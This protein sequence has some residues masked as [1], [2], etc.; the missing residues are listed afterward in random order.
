MGHFEMR[1]L[2]RPLNALVRV[3][4]SKSLTNRALVAAALARGTSTLTNLLVADDTERMLDVLQALGI[5]LCV[6]SERHKATV[7]GCG[8]HIPAGEAELFTGGA[9]TVMRFATAMCA[10]GHG[11]YRLDGDAQ[12]RQRPIADLVAALRSLGALVDY[13]GREGFPPVVVHARGLAGG[14]VSFESPPSSQMVSAVLLAA[15]CARSDVFVEVAGAL[16]SEPYLAMTLEVMDAFG[17]TVVHEALRRFIVP[18]PQIYQSRTFAI[19]PDASNASYFLAAPAVAGGQVTVEGLGTD[20]VQGDARF[21]H[22]LEQMGCVVQRAPSRL[23]VGG[24]PAGSPL[25]AVNVDLNDMP[26]M[27]QTLAVVALFADG[28]TRIRNVANLRF[29]ETDRLAAL[30]TELSR[31]G[32][33]VELYDDGLVVVPPK[34]IE[35]AHVRTYDDHRMA[36]SFSLLCLVQDGVVIAG[37]ECVR[38]T[39]PDYFERFSEMCAA[40]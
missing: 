27:V 13:E 31:L 39:F 12:M 6:A 29:K 5:D 24:P 23:T 10:A 37:A 22:V 26:D 1:P 30:G 2:N 21:V 15:P 3:P 18:A 32:A 35:P 4:G 20:S 11:T 7:T 14:T 9:G 40:G 28:P 38:K 33:T 34:A 19:E 36:M 8:G 17:V 25:K 16:P